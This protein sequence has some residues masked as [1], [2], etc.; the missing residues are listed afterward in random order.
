M[1]LSP[2]LQAAANS[3]TDTL[4]REVKGAKAALISTEDGFEIAARVEN[5]AQVSR[6]SAMASSMAALGA[7]AGEESQLG[8]CNSLLM[9]ADQGFMVIVQIRRADASLILS[10]I[11]GP[12][13]VVG[14]L[15]YFCR[16][17]A[18]VLEALP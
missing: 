3:A 11:T 9:Q 13:A 15:L 12:D 10:V 6:L 2:H 5:T 18:L 7:M 16:H 17:A 4:M 1:T 14:Q 8:Q